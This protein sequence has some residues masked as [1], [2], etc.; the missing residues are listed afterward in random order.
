MKS[1]RRSPYPENVES[2]LMRFCLRA[3]ARPAGFPLQPEKICSFFFSDS[4][5]F[6]KSEN[7]TVHMTTSAE[8]TIKWFVLGV[9]SHLVYLVSLL[10]LMASLP[11]SWRGKV[12]MSGY[13]EGQFGGTRSLRDHDA[14]L[15]GWVALAS[16]IASL[17]VIR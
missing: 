14:L 8:N 12:L 4:Q 11:D 9:L 7:D 16:V 10:F 1:R 6:H 17:V 13:R 3:R 2:Y 5:A 15:L